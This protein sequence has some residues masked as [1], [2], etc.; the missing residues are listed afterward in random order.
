MAEASCLESRG[1]YIDAC[2]ALGNTLGVA[3]GTELFLVMFFR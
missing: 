2:L 3:Y 1:G